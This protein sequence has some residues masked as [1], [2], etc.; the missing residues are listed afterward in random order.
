MSYQVNSVILNVRIMN[1]PQ[2]NYIMTTNKNVFYFVIDGISSNS[3]LVTYKF[4]YFVESDRAIETEWF[5]NQN[6][7]SAPQITLKTIR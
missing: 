7:S 2:Q 3:T 6:S 1:Y 5:T 4:C